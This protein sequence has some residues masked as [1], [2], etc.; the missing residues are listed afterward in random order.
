MDKAGEKRAHGAVA[1]AFARHRSPTV[2]DVGAPELVVEL[3]LQP[4]G[5]EH[6]P[7]VFVGVLEDPGFVRARRD[8]ALEGVVKQPQRVVAEAFA[9]GDQHVDDSA[10]GT[11]AAGKGSTRDHTRRSGSS[12][13]VLKMPPPIAPVRCGRW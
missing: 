13:G 10:P 7:K 1:A 3:E 4:F 11:S 8:E 2:D 12:A 9:G 5:G 6:P